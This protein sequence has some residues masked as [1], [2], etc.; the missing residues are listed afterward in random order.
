M[1]V[2]KLIVIAALLGAA[3]V[4]EEQQVQA[5]KLSEGAMVQDFNGADE[6]EIMDKVF[7]KYA[8]EGKD[9]NGVKNGV[10]I[11]L[12]ATAPKAAGVI[13]EATHK[14]KGSQV[15]GYIKA[16]FER[17]WDN[18]DINGDGFIKAEETHTFMRS[19]MGKL[20][21]F[22]L[23]PGSLSDIG[24]AGLSVSDSSAAAPEEAPKPKPAAKKAAPKPKPAPKKVEEPAQTEASAD[25]DAG[26]AT[27]ASNDAAAA[28]AEA[29]LLAEAGASDAT[30]VELEAAT[31]N[32]LG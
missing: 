32:I 14:L 17:T 5:I 31:S 13:L 3:F 8:T 27:D 10:K 29:A 21:K 26:A 18:F 11:L 16:N 12:K 1:R 22:A 20:N 23:A 15:P 19:L 7:S 4:T 25:A 9:H 24:S 6:D 30:A 28:E 2:T